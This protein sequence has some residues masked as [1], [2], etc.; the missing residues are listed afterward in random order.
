MSSHKA[1]PALGAALL[2]GVSTPLAKLLVGEVTPLLLAGLLYVGSGLGLGALLL[3]RRALARLN[4]AEVTPLAVPPRDVP[5]LLGAIVAGGMA[6]PALLMAGLARTSAAS[7]SLLL[8]MEGVGTAV[9][10]WLVFQENTE[11][12][13]VLG[14][15]AIVAGGVLLAW[16][17]G[18]SAVAPGALLIV[19]ACLCWAIDNNLTR[20]VST[21]DAMM[22]AG[23]KGLLAGVFNTALALA[24]GATLPAR[25]VIERAL[26]L[27]FAGYGLSL[28]LFVVALRTLGTARTSAYFSTAPLFGVALAFVLWPE[29]PDATFWAAAGLMGLGLWLHLRERHAHEHTHLPLKHGH[30][31]SHDEH[32]KHEHDFAWDGK[33]PHV[34]PHAHAVQTHTHVHFPDVHHRHS[35]RHGP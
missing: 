4:G 30:P 1:V 15:L 28:M 16:Q 12:R 32:H 31:H 34:H 22:I 18:G 20:K 10:A 7:A 5:W 19:G 26:L 21:H 13:I 17:P 11:R 6:G 8:N 29:L 33:E 9:L 3:I 25:T 23:L 2:F 14:M 27:G 35:H 24:T